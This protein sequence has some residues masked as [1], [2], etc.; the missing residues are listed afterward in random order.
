MPKR[1]DPLPN[2]T[3]QEKSLQTGIGDLRRQAEQLK[4]ERERLEA[5]R[6]QASQ[7]TDG[8]SGAQAAE[9]M[10]MR[11]R[12]AELLAK[13]SKKD[14][15]PRKTPEKASTEEGKTPTEILPR[16]PGESP[17][18][19]RSPEPLPTGGT[20]KIV[21]PLALAQALFRTGD[22]D[23]ALAAYRLIDVRRVGRQERAA[24]QYMTACCLRKL[25]KADEAAALYR[26]V[27]NS[28]EDDFL[29]DCAQWQLNAMQ[30][31]KEMETQ[32]KQLRQ[33]RLA[34]EVKP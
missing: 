8:D 27:A 5:E 21:D 12:L 29:V 28:K 22:Y 33:R 34:L 20:E 19:R 3:S 6:Q 7:S 16:V 25:G 13:L 9:M 26:E 18:P 30:W 31:R 23:S 11:R 14:Q 10:K 4:A 17:V 2:P 32:L 24:V 15:Q 1:L